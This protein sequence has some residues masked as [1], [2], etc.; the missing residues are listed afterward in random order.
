MD[1]TLVR[2][3]LRDHVTADEPPF[4]LTAGGIVAAGRR[5]R[6]QRLARLA[7]VAAAVAAAVAVLP[8]VVP[9]GRPGT[10]PGDQL[11]PPVELGPGPG[12]AAARPRPDHAVDP[13]NGMAMTPEAV[14]W[15]TYAIT[16]HLQDALP[17]LLPRGM[18]LGPLG[19]ETTFLPTLPAPGQTQGPAES[20]PEQ[21]ATG[22]FMV[23]ASI[24]DE[25]GPGSFSLA[26]SVLDPAYDERTYRERRCR[27]S[28]EECTVSETPDGA[29][30]LARQVSDP[31][32]G[33]VIHLVEVFA[34]KT[35][36]YANSTN[37]LT[38]GSQVL[39]P[40]PTGGGSPAVSP[41]RDQPPLSLDQVIEIAT[42]SDLRLFE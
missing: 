37:R 36:I 38:D 39:S 5:S 6:R 3:A 27:L 28:P 20:G 41:L 4:G 16:C 34:E 14:E 30:V 10:P 25:A 40:P 7:G 35:F 42:H 32:T 21:Y 11:L 9:D 17:D 8:I 26:L 1:D 19:L 33:Y 31:D 2:H 24:T 29:L 18:V 12:C 15:V 23:D 22:Q 13:A